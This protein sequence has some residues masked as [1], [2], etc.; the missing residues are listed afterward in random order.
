[1]PWQLRNVNL[2]VRR[3]R[4]RNQPPLDAHPTFFVQQFRF[5][6][7]PT[8]DDQI[9]GNPKQPSARL[10]Y[11]LFPDARLVEPNECFLCNVLG[12]RA[13]IHVVPEVTNQT[14]TALREHLFGFADSR[15]VLAIPG[16]RAPGAA[17]PESSMTFQ[18]GILTAEL[19]YFRRRL[20]RL[21]ILPR[22]K[23][24]YESLMKQDLTGCPRGAEC[25]SVPLRD[26]CRRKKSL[27]I[28]LD[29]IDKRCTGAVPGIPGL[30]DVPNPVPF[31]AILALPTHEPTCAGGEDLL[32]PPA[33]SFS[34]A[35]PAELP[36]SPVA[37]WV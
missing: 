14:L 28:R 34:A 9:V 21:S 7:A 17:M 12:L 27:L 30:R 15:L 10:E 2:C 11:F 18:S 13:V 22:R 6:L 37:A 24:S 35:D 16:Q 5:L 29:S 4:G 36:A 25:E 19:F 20:G 3:S 1:M 31:S 33:Q 32:F 23:R 8:I 26:F